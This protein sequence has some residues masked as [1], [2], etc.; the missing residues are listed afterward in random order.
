MSESKDLLKASILFQE[1]REEEQPQESESEGTFD[2][3]AEAS[4]IAQMLLQQA[5][6][7]TKHRESK[8]TVTSHTNYHSNLKAIK[9]EDKHIM[10]R[11]SNGSFAIPK[12]Q[13]LKIVEVLSSPS[14]QND[15]IEETPS[16]SEVCMQEIVSP[17]RNQ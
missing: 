7:N 1:G 8:L 10:S 14:K 13:Q 9:E 11:F 3:V 2:P 17:F 6:G 4:L 15:A 5:V 16:N 12:N